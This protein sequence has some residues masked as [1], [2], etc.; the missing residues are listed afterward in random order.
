MSGV[1]VGGGV[2]NLPPPGEESIEFLQREI[3]LLKRRIVD[4]RH[5][6]GDKAIVQVRIPVEKTDPFC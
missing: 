6:L 3:E 2:D 1:G 5:K 4:E